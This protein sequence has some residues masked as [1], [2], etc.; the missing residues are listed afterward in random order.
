[1]ARPKGSTNRTREEEWQ[2]TFAD[3]NLEDQRV[4][5]RV[6]EH[7]PRIAKQAARA[8][9]GTRPEAVPSGDQAA[10]ALGTGT[11]ESQP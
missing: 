10:L 5:L 6:L 3:W 11:E 4:A 2:D 9:P 7:I 1:M 8:E